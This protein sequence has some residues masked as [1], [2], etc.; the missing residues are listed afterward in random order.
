MI[1]VISSLILGITAWTLAEYLLH[2]FLGHEHKGRNFFKDEHATHH[3]VANYFA[4]AYKKIV[5][6]LIAGCVLFFSIS[7][8]LPGSL[9]LSFLIGFFGMY[10]VYEITHYRFHTAHP[11]RIFIFLRKH[12]FYHHFHNPSKNHGVTTRLWDRV[13]GTFHVPEKVRVPRS[14]MMG[15]LVKDNEVKPEYAQHFQLSGRR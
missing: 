3:S 10:G 12:H 7:M 11:F 14:M 15:W 9:V 6:A 8:V 4:P 13:F 5:A 1:A 2:R